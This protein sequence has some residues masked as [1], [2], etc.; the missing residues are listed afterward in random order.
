MRQ[1]K[2]IFLGVIVVLSLSLLAIRRDH[3]T[4]IW[5]KLFDERMTTLTYIFTEDKWPPSVDPKES[6]LI[7]NLTFMEHLVGTL[8]KFNDA[9]VYE[10]Y[11]AEKW[12]VSPDQKY[13]EFT[14]RPDLKFEDGLIISANQYIESIEILLKI[15]FANTDPPAFNK[16]IGWKDFWNGKEKHIRGLLAKNDR[17]IAF[18]F[19]SVPEGFIDF[20]AM[21]YFGFF[22]PRDFSRSAWKN[23][24][25]ITSSAS[26]RIVS[27]SDDEIV[28]EARNKWFSILDGTANK[29]VFRKADYETALKDTSKYLIIKKNINHKGAEFKGFKI[30]KST[31]TYLVFISPSPYTKNL[32][33]LES[34]RRLF[35]KKIRIAQDVFVLDSEIS[36]PTKTFYPSD[37]VNS[38]TQDL[39]E[40]MIQNETS[41]KPLKISIMPSVNGSGREYVLKI[42]EQALSSENI[43]YKIYDLD[44][45]N[46]EWM[47]KL[48]SNKEYDIRIGGVDIGG[49]PEN[50]VIKM[51]F[52]SVLGICFPDPSNRICN[53]TEKLP[54][55][56]NDVILNDYVSEFNTI[57]KEDAAVIPVY[58]T[59]HTW[60]FS[61]SINLNRVT[62]T[63]IVPRFDRLQIK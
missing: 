10:P 42:L 31:P 38:E 54:N 34:N 55:R 61:D 18:E 33:S 27:W 14:L 30:V 7:F 46:P 28:L 40:K 43:P 50:W 39:S 45:S 3:L 1:R 57:L 19:E 60:L 62:P 13:W 44:K 59:G 36:I 16:L 49:R 5:H 26:H 11:M 21:P 56:P 52:C 4:Q 37:F 47:R 23:K 24:N 15:N 2:W 12:S 41:A 48:Y 63:M 6:D 9:G 29:V 25:S 17:I 53:L 35:L 20:L 58:H 22:H 32:F 51:M 8:V